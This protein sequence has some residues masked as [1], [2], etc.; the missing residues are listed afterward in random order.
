MKNPERIDNELTDV[1]HLEQMTQEPAD[2]LREVET[3]ELEQVAGGG[4]GTAIGYD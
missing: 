1:A 3:A 2:E 4:N